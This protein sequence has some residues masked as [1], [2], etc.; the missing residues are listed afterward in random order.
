[1]KLF[2]ETAEIIEF[3]LAFSLHPECQSKNGKKTMVSQIVAAADQVFLIEPNA[4]QARPAV[5][6]E[7]GDYVRKEFKLFGDDGFTFRDFLDMINPLQHIP[8]VG[9]IYREITGDEIDPGAKLFGSTVLGGPIGAIVSVI[10]V[11]IK[12]NTGKDMGEHTVAMF[13]GSGGAGDAPADTGDVPTEVASIEAGIA[14][15]P[16]RDLGQSPPP[17]GIGF[18]ATPAAPVQTPGRDFAAAGMSLIPKISPEKA[19]GILDR[20]TNYAPRTAPD[21]QALADFDTAAGPPLGTGP[22]LAAGNIVAPRPRPAAAPNQP[23][24][25]DPR[26]PIDEYPGSASA[27]PGAPV[28]G[29]RQAA[30]SSQLAAVEQVLADLKQDWLTQ[31]M[32]QAL[33]KYESGRRLSNLPSA[34]ANSVLR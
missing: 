17:I 19:A 9:T 6:G 7:S 20:F 31:S 25:L 15:I 10:D 30:A 5:S 32:M 4:G 28:A 18:N 16:G 29:I 14:P 13:T 11:V 12:H 8:V 34:P 33:D 23:L 22:P 3:I 26:Y 2:P 24:A 27:R 1:M 21:L